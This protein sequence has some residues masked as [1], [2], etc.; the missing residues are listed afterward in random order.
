MRSIRWAAAGSGIAGGD[1]TAVRTR[2]IQC[3]D[4]P[5]RTG[6]VG[7]R[8]AAGPAHKHFHR[9]NMVAWLTQEAAAS[10]NAPHLIR[11]AGPRRAA[12]VRVL[13][14]QSERGPTRYARGRGETGA[15]LV[16]DA[17]AARG[18]RRQELARRSLVEANRGWRALAPATLAEAEA[19]CH[20]IGFGP[21][22]SLLAAFL[23]VLLV[24]VTPLAGLAFAA[25]RFA[26]AGFGLR[27]RWAS[28]AHHGERPAEEARQRPTPGVGRHKRTGQGI[29]G[30]RVHSSPPQRMSFPHATPGL[31]Y[32]SS[33][34]VRI[35]SQLTMT[36]QT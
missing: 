30:G 29:E 23:A 15:V 26:F 6:R 1:A 20:S 31:S 11:H 22:L 21:A 27:L 4:H 17:G 7:Q 16:A 10:R 35:S 33:W 2:P 32:R 36:C 9:Q 24:A 18:G 5:G 28:H 14:A 13:M 34:V 19:A 25:G 12:R 8:A 3:A